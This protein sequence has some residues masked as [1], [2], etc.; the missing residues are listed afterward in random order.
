MAGMVS[1]VEGYVS[2]RYGRRGSGIHLGLDIAG[3]GKSKKVYAA[4]AGKIVEIVRGV[5][6]GSRKSSSSWAPGRTPNLIIIQNPD[7]EFQLYGHCLA[8]ARWKEGDRVEAG[9]YLGKT[10]LSGNTTGYHLHFEIWPSRYSTRNPEIDFRYFGIKVGSTPKGISNSPKAWG[11][12]TSSKPSSK[13]KAPSVGIKG[14][15]KKMGLPQTID[16]VKRWQR[17]HGLVADGDWGP[18]SERYY[19]WVLELQR[20]LNT[21]KNVK[22]HYP[23][24]IPVDGYRG[25]T[26]KRAEGYARA[27]ATA[28]VPYNPP[29][30]PRKRP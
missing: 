18:V 15:L 29:K 28:S 3:G 14:R 13:P 22:R 16:G 1:P 23:N 25:A 2:S 6:H 17:A 10:D 11:G 20:Y 24:G 12:N 9:D 30:E 4:F 26:T 8:D 27:G 7:G 19:Q 21:W 5:P